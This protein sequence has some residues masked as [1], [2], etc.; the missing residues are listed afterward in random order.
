MN[1]L[2]RLEIQRYLDREADSEEMLAWEQHLTMCPRCTKER[3]S[4]QQELEEFKNLLDLS[5]TDMTD[6]EIPVF[7]SSVAENPLRNWAM[8]ASAASILLVLGITWNL[9]RQHQSAQCNI[10][11]NNQINAN[12]YNED[13]NKLWNE[14]ASVI[15]IIDKDGHLIYSSLND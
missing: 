12:L 5:N 13:A 8:Y 15:T 2:N 4:A 9:S 14:K 11:I 10:N 6:F 3:E 7:Q 1:C